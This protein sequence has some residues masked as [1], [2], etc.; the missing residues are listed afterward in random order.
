[1]AERCRA[2]ENYLTMKE[3]LKVLVISLN[4]LRRQYCTLLLCFPVVPLWVKYFLKG[5]HS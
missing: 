1:M 4:T 2:S 5:C 3:H